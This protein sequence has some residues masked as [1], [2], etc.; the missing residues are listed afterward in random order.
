MELS[1]CRAIDFLIE[2]IIAGFVL[3][4]LLEAIVVVSVHDL[5]TMKSIFLTNSA[6]F[7]EINYNI[8][9]F[10]IPIVSLRHHETVHN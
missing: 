9:L 1:V 3:L 4:C 6:M 10:S 8:D 7:I 5:D 2:M